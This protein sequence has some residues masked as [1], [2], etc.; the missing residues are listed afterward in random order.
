MIV[1]QLT[2]TKAILKPALLME[3]NDR[4][5]TVLLQNQAER[6]SDHA[7]NV[8]SINRFV[9][10]STSMFSPCGRNYR[11]LRTPAQSRKPL[12]SKRPAIQTPLRWD[13]K[14]T[15]YRLSYTFVQQFR[16]VSYSCCTK[17]FSSNRWQQRLFDRVSGNLTPV[18]GDT[19]NGCSTG[20]RKWLP[21]N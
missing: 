21:T 4:S 3:K 11:R 13:S 5:S 8:T 7:S 20:Q 10:V 16:T 18:M 12:F 2:V 19:I 14:K 6:D 9:A 15:S 17:F 1:C